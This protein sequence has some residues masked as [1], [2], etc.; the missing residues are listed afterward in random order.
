MMDA[1]SISN[2]NP[3]VRASYGLLVAGLVGGTIGFIFSPRMSIVAAAVIFGW[4]QIG[5]L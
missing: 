3:L 1:V 2:S 4:S 5:G